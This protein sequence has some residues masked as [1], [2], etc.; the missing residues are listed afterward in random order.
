[1]QAGCVQFFHIFC[2]LC[3]RK[4]MA[5]ADEEDQFLFRHRYI[6]V[7]GRHFLTA[8]I[9]RPGGGH[10][11]HVLRQVDVAACGILLIDGGQHKT[12]AKEDLVLH[13]GS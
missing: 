7:S 4:E 13:L 9:L 3:Q 10:A 6:V 8:E 5:F 12:L 2:R 11:E 1:M